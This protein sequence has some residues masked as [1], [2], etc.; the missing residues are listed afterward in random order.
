MIFSYHWNYTKR[1]NMSEKLYQ[2]AMK[3]DP[4]NIWPTCNYATFIWSIR[5]NYE[6]SEK[7]IFF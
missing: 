4:T 3:A 5:N 7:V 1:Y 2:L 6:E